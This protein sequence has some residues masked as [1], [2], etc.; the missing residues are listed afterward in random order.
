MAYISLYNL[1]TSNQLFPF[2]VVTVFVCGH[3]SPPNRFGSTLPLSHSCNQ[4]WTVS[5]GP[6]TSPPIY[7]HHHHHHS[8]SLAVSVSAGVAGRGQVSGSVPYVLPFLPSGA[9]DSSSV[10]QPR[11]RLGRQPPRDVIIPGEIAALARGCSCLIQRLRE[12][13][14]ANNQQEKGP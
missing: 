5:S 11:G 4:R 6:P 12:R 8:P 3:W 2:C 7:H 14:V 9:P 10:C 1:I 13:G